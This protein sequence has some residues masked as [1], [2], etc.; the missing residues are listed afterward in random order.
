M[1]KNTIPSILNPFSEFKC[2]KH[3]MV[4]PETDSIAIAMV[5]E[6]KMYGGFVNINFNIPDKKKNNINKEEEIMKVIDG[7]LN[8]LV[9]ITKNQINKLKEKKNARA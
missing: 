5:Y 9:K 3:K 7:Y 4:L 6:G 2:G 1:K 8:F